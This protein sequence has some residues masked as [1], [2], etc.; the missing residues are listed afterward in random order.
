MPQDFVKR[1]ANAVPVE[2]RNKGKGLLG[3][4]ALFRPQLFPAEAGSPNCSDRPLRGTPEFNC[5]RS[6]KQYW[7]HSK[8]KLRMVKGRSKRREPMAVMLQ[9]LSSAVVETETAT[10]LTPA[11]TWTKRT[12]RQLKCI[13]M[14]KGNTIFWCRTNWAQV[15][16]L[17]VMLTLLSWKRKNLKGGLDQQECKNIS[18]ACLSS[19]V[20][21][22]FKLLKC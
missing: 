10:C 15:A 5:A 2:N 18:A 1:L 7:A 4:T 8:S 19:S 21:F 20:H 9:S 16:F 13:C 6:K 22:S 3:R 11:Y 17:P 12:Q 14:T